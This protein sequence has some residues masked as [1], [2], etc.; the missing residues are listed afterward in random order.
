MVD[1]LGG[2]ELVWKKN[3][4]IIAIGDQIV[5]EFAS[6]FSI[7]K[8]FSGN[9]LVIR[10]VKIT[11]EAKFSCCVSAQSE[12]E[13]DHNVKVIENGQHEL[14][15]RKKYPGIAGNELVNV[16][17]V[18]LQEV[19]G[20]VHTNNLE[21]QIYDKKNN[22]EKHKSLIQEETPA[23]KIYF[24]RV[25]SFYTFP[26]NEKNPVTEQK[27]LIK[28][29]PKSVIEFLELLKTYQN[30]VL[31]KDDIQEF[32]E[33]KIEKRPIPNRRL[34][35]GKHAYNSNLRESLQSANI[36]GIDDKNVM[37]KKR[38]NH[39]DMSQVEANAMTKAVTSK[40]VDK[41]QKPE[42][43]EVVLTLEEGS[44][45]EEESEHSDED[46]EKDAADKRRASS[47][48]RKIVHF[49]KEV[50]S[51]DERSGVDEGQGPE[52]EEEVLTLEEEIGVEEEQEHSDE[53]SFENTN[54]KEMR[55]ENELDYQ[56]EGKGN[57]E[58]ETVDAH[59]HIGERYISENNIGIGEGDEIDISEEEKSATLRG[60]HLPNKDLDSYGLDFRDLKSTGKKDSKKDT[61]SPSKEIEKSKSAATIEFPEH[62][63]VTNNMAIDSDITMEDD[64]E[65]SGYVTEEVDELLIT[66]PE[67]IEN[68]ITID[69]DTKMDNDEKSSGFIKEEVKQQKAS[70]IPDTNIDNS[71]YSKENEYQEKPLYTGQ[72]F[73][74][75]DENSKRK[76]NLFN[77][78]KSPYSLRYIKEGEIGK[79]EEEKEATT[80]K[81][82]KPVL[83]GQHIPEA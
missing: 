7:E 64:E 27:Q 77:S 81:R 69:L 34:L 78:H 37:N 70:K 75:T 24:A 40:G 72:H 16:A 3:N 52:G 25:P 42:D 33:F 67:G 23:G 55:S 4:Q 59:Y 11:D 71:M 5:D 76:S 73:D 1:N 22:A 49:E 68:D 6:E 58:Q 18:T 30:S 56:K 19:R 31:T 82:M 65:S 35:R 83:R 14:G 79:V 15:T 38:V 45:V 36:E 48:E 47:G 50:S 2:S 46:E 13:V 80:K 32:K 61:Y 54:D 8:C 57:S 66:K 28:H 43:E 21:N 53:R 9:T 41:G 62:I 51:T 74:A 44:G 39:M 29:A 20:E 10:N 60:E 26:D 17:D 12:I 63:D